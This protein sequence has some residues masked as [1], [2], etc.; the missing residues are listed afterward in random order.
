MYFQ[1]DNTNVRVLGSM[2]FFPE[3]VP[4]VPRW[5]LDAYEWA[6]DIALEV[7]WTNVGDLFTLSE[8]ELLADYVSADIWAWLNA[9]WPPEYGELARKPAWLAITQVSQIGVK[10]QAGLDLHI[11]ALA[12]RDGKPLHFLETAAEFSSM[13]QAVPPADI[14]TALR[15]AIANYSEN[16]KS[17][18]GLY[19]DWAKRDLATMYRRIQ[20]K[21]I[22]TIPSIRHAVLTDRNLSWVSGINE[23][24]QSPRKVLVVVGGLHLY[25][26][27][28]LL[29]QL[30]RAITTL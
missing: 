15:E 25:G 27:G 10:L 16:D 26:E 30:G 19:A 8:G 3:T 12:Q 18:K 7:D 9:H 2:H 24:C 11:R 28:N 1:I 21:A 17:F 6:D 5:A 29:Q 13:M 23:L 14:E 4:G 20:K 22:A